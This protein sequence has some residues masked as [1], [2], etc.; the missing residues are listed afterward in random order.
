VPPTYYEIL[1]ERGFK[2]KE[3]LDELKELGIL[4]DTEGK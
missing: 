1:K 4:C 2:V 3:N